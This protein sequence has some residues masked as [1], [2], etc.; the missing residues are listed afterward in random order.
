MRMA[1]PYLSLFHSWRHILAAEV[2]VFSAIFSSVSELTW[3]VTIWLFLLNF[4]F[5]SL[6]ICHF[7]LKII[8]HFAPLVLFILFQSLPVQYL[9]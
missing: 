5:L 4:A 6:I 1:T 3:L 7:Y 9:N 2:L 8:P